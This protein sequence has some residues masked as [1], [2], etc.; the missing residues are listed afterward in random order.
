[1]S[2]L[3]AKTVN[4]NIYLFINSSLVSFFICFSAVWTN[5]CLDS[6]LWF[7]SY[8]ISVIS[9]HMELSVFFFKVN[10]PALG[11]QPCVFCV[12]DFLCPGYIIPLA[13]CIRDHLVPS[14]TAD[15]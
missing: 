13:F 12:L 8:N 3:F 14:L 11:L 5:R 9:I 4:P 6:A 1:M 7:A 15:A 10:I 2:K